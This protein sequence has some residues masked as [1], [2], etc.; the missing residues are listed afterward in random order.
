MKSYTYVENLPTFP[1]LKT[2]EENGRRYYLLPSGKYVPS[3]TTMLGF[4]KKD[5]IQEWRK[6]VGEQEAN[7]ISN[8]ASTHGTK[9]HNLLQKYL[10]NT[11]LPTLLNDSVMPNMKQAFY[12]MESTLDRIDNIH[13]IESSLYSEKMRLAGRIDVIAEFDGVLSV[14]DFKTSSKVKTESMIE[15]YFLQATCYALMFEER[16]DRPI[17][18]IVII[19][20]TDGLNE[21]QVFVR[22]KTDYIDK[23]FEKILTFHREI[24]T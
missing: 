8:R 19:I 23:L 6:R 9:F 20:S 2:K 18:Q 4:F 15:D 21:P 11:P 12:D 24:K 14:I 3:V 10:E 16:T 1:S 5:V 17:D 7:K 13:Y 22:N